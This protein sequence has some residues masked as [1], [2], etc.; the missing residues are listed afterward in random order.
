MDMQIIISTL[1]VIVVLFA[2]YFN[3]KFIVEKRAETDELLEKI[4]NYEYD[5]PA[6]WE[7]GTT[8]KMEHDKDN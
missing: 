5:S 4:I 3:I 1:L 7:S 6:V 8:T 2:L